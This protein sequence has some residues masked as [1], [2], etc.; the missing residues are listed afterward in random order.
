[1]KAVIVGFAAFCIW[2]STLSQA[3]LTSDRLMLDVLLRMATS[4]TKTILQNDSSGLS[5][6]QLPKYDCESFEKAN[7]HLV[8]LNGDRLND[9]VYHGPC[10]GAPQ[11]AA[12]IYNGISFQKVLDEAGN[13]LAINHS[14]EGAQLFLYNP[15]AEC[16]EDADRIGC[17]QLNR[18]G[19]LVSHATLIWRLEDTLPAR[20]DNI[21]THVRGVVRTSPNE[22]D[23]PRIASC[24]GDTLLGN[25]LYATPDA[26]EALL[27]RTCGDWQQVL[28]PHGESNF[29]VAWIQNQFQNMHPNAILIQRFYEGFQEKN[30]RQ[31]GECYHDSATFQDPV[32]TLK[33]GK[34]AR[35]MWHF[36]CTNGKD[37]KVIFSD[38][39]ADDHQGS[40]HWEATYTF[41]G[42]GR[43]V[44]N[45]IDAKFEFKDGKIIVHKDSF[46][47]YKWTRMALGTTGTLLGWTP[48]V[49]NKV[50]GTAMGGLKKFMADKPEY[51]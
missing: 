36:L 13:I 4:P 34:E 24:F 44:H 3:N 42:T 49:K 30:Y 45:V 22:D 18:R 12:F 20:P 28:I 6:I 38:V 21:P 35:A 11:T 14:D 32:F 26:T 37:L 23:S 29:R 33:N 15:A 8:D 27:L 41:S 19:E 17:Y 31:M 9:L 51:Q 48:L 46:K 1:M 25:R 7:F 10:K 39:Q 40:A 16:M 43:K 5:G 50:R 47:F 2:S